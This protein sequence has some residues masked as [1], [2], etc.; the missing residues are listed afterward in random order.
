MSDEGR[1]V[2]W[3]GANDHRTGVRKELS[4][5]EVLAMTARPE[6]KKASERFLCSWIWQSERLLLL[7][8]RTLATSGEARV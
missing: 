8:V 7:H 3:K 4:N 5:E 1:L 2:L 6:G